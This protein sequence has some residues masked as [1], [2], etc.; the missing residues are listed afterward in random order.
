[1]G[2]ANKAGIKTRAAEQSCELVLGW[3]RTWFVVL[4]CAF[5][6]QGQARVTSLGVTIRQLLVIL[7][8]NS[9][10]RKSGSLFCLIEDNLFTRLQRVEG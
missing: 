6:R 8:A 9:H 7:E 10:F 4:G 2:C 1:M 3:W 5:P